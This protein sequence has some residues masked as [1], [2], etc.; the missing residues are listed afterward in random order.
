MT[1]LPRD[2]ASRRARGPCALQMDSRMTDLLGALGHPVLRLAAQLLEL[3]PVL[4]HRLASLVGDG[5]AGQRRLALELL[6]HRDEP[7][8]LQL[9]QVAGEVALRQARE[10][11]QVE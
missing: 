4:L 11:L 3:T 5:N 2:G 7:H 9:G 6:L 8:L 1:Y 10:A